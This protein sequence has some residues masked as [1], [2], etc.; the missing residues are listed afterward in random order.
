MNFKNTEFYKLFISLPSP[1]ECKQFDEDCTWSAIGTY[2][3]TEVIGSGDPLW[4]RVLTGIITITFGIPLIPLLI[5]K[6][7][8]CRRKVAQHPEEFL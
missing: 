8:R 6:K 2:F 7:Y 4:A 3:K 1:V 5:I